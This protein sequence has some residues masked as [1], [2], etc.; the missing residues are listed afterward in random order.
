MRLLI[1]G[2]VL[3]LLAS[4]VAAQQLSPTQSLVYLQRSNNALAG[5]I[6]TLQQADGDAKLLAAM[7]DYT[8]VL[9]EQVAEYQ[10][11]QP[12]KVNTLW[13]VQGYAEEH[14]RARRLAQQ[15]A[16][17]Y[18]KVAA[19]LQNREIREAAEQMMRLNQLLPAWVIE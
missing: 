18:Q 19:R 4:Q 3:V 7:Q 8:A 13:L 12:A 16:E 11:A 10:D 9:A 14:R 1:L 17:V 6:G 15:F 5:L 2:G